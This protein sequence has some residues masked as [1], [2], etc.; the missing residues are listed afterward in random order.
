MRKIIDRKTAYRAVLLLVALV[1][2]LSIWPARLWTEV[3]D[4]SAGGDRIEE[5]KLVNFE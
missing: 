5:D 3:M 1:T 2:V 4:T